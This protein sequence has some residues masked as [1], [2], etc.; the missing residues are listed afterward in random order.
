MKANNYNLQTTSL[1]TS[2]QN[3]LAK[4]PNQD[5]ARIMRTLLYSSG[6]GSQFWSY[7]LQHSVYLKNRCP[8]ATLDYMTPYER[9][10]G[11]KPDLSRLRIFGSRVQVQSAGKRKMKLDSICSS[12]LFITYKGTDKICYIVNEDRRNE[13]A[14]THVSFDKAHLSVPHA[15]QPPI[16]TIL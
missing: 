9:V 7:A 8:H 10:N 16:S 3:A 13:R 2:A 6:L 1:Y 11:K 4:K 15:K 14:S 5:L 12:G